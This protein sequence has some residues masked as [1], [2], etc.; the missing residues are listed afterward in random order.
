M[1]RTPPPIGERM[2]AALNDVAH[3]TV[4]WVRIGEARRAEAVLALWDAM[5]ADEAAD[6]IEVVQGSRA[7]RAFASHLAGTLGMSRNAAVT[8]LHT[9][10]AIRGLPRTH[11]S[12]RGGE[13]GWQSVEAVVRHLGALRGEAREQYDEGA[14]AIATETVPQL[15]DPEL[16][17]LHDALDHDAATM[18]AAAAFRDRR[19]RAR[20]GVAGEASLT[21]T[22]P[23]ADIAAWYE[24]LR[25]SAVA[26]HAPDEQHRSVGTLMYDIGLDVGL[27]GLE[28][29]PVE[30]DRGPQGALVPAD[31]FERLGDPRVPHRKAIQAEI[32]VMVPAET[33]CGASNRPGTI[34]G[35]GS[36]AAAEVRRLIAS[37]RFW[38]R[39][40][41]DP[42][43]DAIL[44]FDSAERAIPKALRRLIHLRADRC[45]EPGCPTGAHLADIDHV[46]R[47]EHGGRTTEINLTALCR[48]GHQ[49]KDDG[50]VDV[51][52][53]DGD[54][55]WNT[56]R[57]GGHFV[58]RS[59]MRIRRRPTPQTDGTDE[60]AP[61]DLSA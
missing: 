17:R 24:K 2:F 9:A 44:A 48:P 52:R 34:A 50:Y 14:A 28:H 32:L 6:G 60:P 54:L 4:R 26:S 53:I 46:I 51:E 19:V 25:R 56:T 22:G 18:N 1:E 10:I 57:W 27:W 35:W 38:T 3:G 29:P 20:P 37:A 59:R 42:V 58:T 43:D 33:A 31:P 5:V 41:T 47:V 39:V 61:W 12:F 21:F 36:L 40:E 55:H 7:E 30:I 23:E 13:F 11:R 8:L 49:T 45:E 15:V 16:A